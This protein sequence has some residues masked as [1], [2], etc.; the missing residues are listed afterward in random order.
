M[1]PEDRLSAVIDATLPILGPHE[2]SLYLL[3]L[4]ET[5]FQGGEVRIGKRTIGARLGKGVRSSGINYQHLTK[6]VN[7]LVSAGFLAVGD[8]TQMGTQYSVKLPTLTE[9]SS[10]AEVADYFTDPELRASLMTRDGWAC[11]YC[12]DSVTPTTATLDHVIPQ[13]KGGLGTTENLKTACITCNSIKSDRTYE[14]AA[15]DILAS[16]VR[17]RAFNRGCP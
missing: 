13:S 3:L 2:F 14:Q 16:V 8:T 5:K 1:S 10:S 4:R 11:C 7:N 17:R 6:K 12:G 15:A 9:A